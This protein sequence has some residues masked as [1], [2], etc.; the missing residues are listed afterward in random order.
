[1]SF[2]PRLRLVTTLV[3]A[4][5]I[6]LA[7]GGPAQA[8]PRLTVDSAALA[9]T[10][11]NGDSGVKQLTIG[12]AGTA[13][14][15]W[16]ATM[17]VGGAPA[18]PVTPAPR[19]LLMTTAW[20]LDDP[21][22]AAL[23]RQSLAHTRVTDW[24]S[25]WI[26]AQYLGPWDLVIVS[27]RV[28]ASE[29]RAFAALAAHL[30]RGGALLYADAQ[31]VADN[32]LL[33]RLGIAPESSLAGTE[34]LVPAAAPHRCFTW[35][36]RIDGFAPQPGPDGDAGVQIVSARGHA[37]ALASFAG[38]PGSGAIVVNAR[39]RALYNAFHA[40]SFLGDADAD[41]LP[42]AVELAENEIAY[43]TTASS[44]VG[45]EPTAGV[46]PPGGSQVVNVG[47]EM[48]TACGGARTARISLASD[49]PTTPYRD[50]TARLAGYSEPRLTSVAEP[51][52]FG[53][54]YIGAVAPLAFRILNDGCAPLRIT[55]VTVDHPAFR[56]ATPTPY[57]AWAR[58][59]N[60]IVVE[61]AP[62]SVEAVTGTVTLTSDD[63]LVPEV[64]VAVAGAGRLSPVV[65]VRSDSLALALAPGETATRHVWISNSGVADLEWSLSPGSA[66]KT[67]ASGE[68]DL[69]GVRIL[70]TR[71]HD[72]EDPYSYS[73]CATL[74]ADLV[75]RGATIAV[76]T[77]PIS[78]GLLRGCDILVVRH[79]WREWTA[80]EAVV[81]RQ[82]VRGGGSLLLDGYDR[83]VM[84]A[85]PA[86]L[87]GSFSFVTVGQPRGLS[88]AIHPHPATAGIA[89]LSLDWIYNSLAVVSPPAA[90]LVD[91]P[92]G[93][94]AIVADEIR[95]GRV[96]AIAPLYTFDNAN[97]LA[98]DNRPF[99]L[100]VFDWLAGP[101]W[102]RATPT[103]GVL[104]PGETREVT[105]DLDA[106]ARCGVTL[107]KVLTLSTNDPLQRTITL[108]VD[109][110]VSGN[111]FLVA[112]ADSLDFGWLYTGQARADTL[113][114]RNEGCEPLTITS[115][116]AGSNAFAV[117]TP[118]PLTIAPDAAAPATVVF[119]PSAPGAAITDLI[120]AG[121]DSRGTTASV[122]LR[123]L[124][125]APPVAMAAP[126]ALA[127]T[128]EPGA[129]VSRTLALANAGQS[130]LTWKVGFRP[131]LS[132][133]PV[134]LAPPAGQSGAGEVPDEALA[135]TAELRDLTGLRICWDVSHGQSLPG[136]WPILVGDLQVRGATVLVNS[137][138]LTPDSLDPL[139]VLWIINT[140]DTW[141]DAE[142]TAVAE[143]IHNGGGLLLEGDSDTSVGVY[144]RILA[145]A[146]VAFRYGT[147]DAL[148]GF[149]TAIHGHA[150]TTDL[151]S[152]HLSGPGARLSGIAPPSQRLVDDTAGTTVAAASAAGAGRVV[153]L[154]DEVFNVWSF[155]HADNRRFGNQVFDWLAI[156]R[157]VRVVPMVGVLP[158][159]GALDLAVN[160]SAAHSGP[161]L[162]TGRLEIASNDPST[163]VI[164][165]PVSL[166][167]GG[168]PDLPRIV[169]SAGNGKLDAVPLV[170]AAAAGA[171]DGFD[172]G[173]DL[174]APEPQPAG[175]A[176]WFPHPEW[177][178]GSGARFL[179]DLRAPFDPAVSTREWSFLVASNQTAA[180]TLE[181]AYNHPGLTS[182][183]LLLVD[184]ATGATV[185]L[186]TAH[187]YTYAAAPG[188][189]EFRLRLGAGLPPPG[190]GVAV[191]DEV[192][193]SLARGWNL[194]EY[195][196]W[197]PGDVSG[198]AVRC[199]GR[200]LAF[201]TAAAQGLLS[202][203]VFGAGA[204]A[205]A[206]PST[207]LRTGQSFWVACHGDGVD[208]V[209]DPALMD[210][211]L[212]A[213]PPPGPEAPATAPSWR[214]SLRID[215]GP[216][217]VE[218]GRHEDAADGFDPEWDL[219][220]PPPLPSAATLPGISIVPPPGAPGCFS[221]LFRD[222]RSARGG[223][224]AFALR[225]AAPSP[226]DVTLAWDAAAL[227][228][229]VDL[230]LW[231]DG[232]PLVTSLRGQD[233]V[234]VS[235]GE[236]P[237]ALLLAAVGSLA[238][239]ST[240]SAGPDLRSRPNPFNPSTEVSFLLDRAG[241]VAV[242]VYD[243]RGVL[244]RSL[245]AGRL[246]AGPAAVV[247][248]G[249]DQHGL[250]VASGTY[251]YRLMQ[252]GVQL[253][254]TRKMVLLK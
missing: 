80:A 141:H 26:Q 67:V 253:G 167:V 130:D 159:G 28:S 146:G 138:P 27:N 15:H 250:E 25:L 126:A 119:A 173:S 165:V 143:W 204:E 33:A 170:A 195:P 47:F 58:S 59:V 113:W 239:A 214:L 29:P 179:A 205:V 62:T 30:D 57:S 102:L 233:R 98:A 196:L 38:H 109:V 112:G 41:G 161:G 107:Q 133:S 117:T 52:D 64:S 150:T 61:F 115:L 51:L 128:L 89:S 65:S 209:L 177:D 193:T 230:G 152:V 13:D 157:W 134:T 225:V 192:V 136:N 8:Q 246:P 197:F 219:P 56:I 71:A 16:T 94:P 76:S 129:T 43:L 34:E 206:S 48:S 45:I 232:A 140:A 114:V 68:I 93:L 169:I 40:D 92:G 104:A 201:A 226:R 229:G 105:I 178:A 37:R 101:R 88:T 176:A 32:Q 156:P 69:T 22:V 238:S 221:G 202:G 234:V 188:E 171:T 180:I 103:A 53:T 199:G 74:I 111:K 189:R 182:H 248:N 131:D 211:A 63:P 215:D 151:V 91:G 235:V 147:A 135:L 95:F 174:A 237:V 191:A 121:D 99:A 10:L 24:I 21:Y 4:M 149:T 11:A 83:Y 218:V 39:R 249:I 181:F 20:R 142:I 210:A 162:H 35:P 123:G 203:L 175:L 72:E 75:A 46:V 12:N 17:A 158:P 50:V 245:D 254:P 184:T 186:H 77:S 124:G 185:N 3:I 120:I 148:A 252:D 42:D 78:D 163:P 19:I 200:Q 36:N 87:G 49:D 242:M 154:C 224:P 251:L 116:A 100:Q 231:R 90:T 236:A 106:A 217:R 7:A 18:T 96:V 122:R 79:G 86:G 220:A 1:M 82:W 9:D 23:T 208:L 137:L 164:R 198:L 2:R 5:V 212:R 127:V 223:A 244:V 55:G 31:S 240:P 139:D 216:A 194:V 187:T 145:A 144:N 73:R 155:F 84:S 172:P 81:L 213:L 241:E 125:V 70:W 97:L 247:W 222:L 153:A 6:G 183:G 132:T 60:D 85:I 54:Q 168:V 160:F 207:C 228:P 108:P 118:L 44:W 14:L 190:T 166:N 227:P 66:V 110:A 243:V